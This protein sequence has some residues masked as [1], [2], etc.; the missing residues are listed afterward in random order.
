ML[1]RIKTYCDNQIKLM[2]IFFHFS[3]APMAGIIFVIYSC[4]SIRKLFSFNLKNVLVFKNIFYFKTNRYLELRVGRWG[5]TIERLKKK[6]FLNAAYWNDH[7][8]AQGANGERPEWE[9]CAPSLHV[10]IE[11]QPAPFLEPFEGGLADSKITWI[12]NRTEMWLK[13]LITVSKCC[14]FSQL[15]LVH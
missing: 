6:F 11:K 14:F 15:Q 13:T 5:E 9:S 1:S 2:D 10:P 3:L 4:F 8:N 7:E 12:R